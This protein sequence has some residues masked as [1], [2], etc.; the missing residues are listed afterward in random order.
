MMAENEF[1]CFFGQKVRSLVLHKQKA[2]IGSPLSS[3]ILIILIFSL[4]SWRL[5][6]FSFLFF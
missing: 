1:T 5:G 6:G 3:A 4:R 2:A